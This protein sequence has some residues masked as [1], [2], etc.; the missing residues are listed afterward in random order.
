VLAVLGV[1]D[2]DLRELR[3]V[4]EREGHRGRAAEVAG[5]RLAARAGRGL[6]E[7]RVL[8]DAVLEGVRPGGPHLRAQGVDRRDV[9]AAVL[10]DEDARGARKAVAQLRDLSFLL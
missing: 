7:Q 4:A 6:P 5:Q 10:R 3:R 8:R 9:E 1:V 2:Q